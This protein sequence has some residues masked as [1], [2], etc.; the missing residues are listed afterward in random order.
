MFDENCLNNEREGQNVWLNCL[1][2]N[3]NILFQIL[4]YLTKRRFC[5]QIICTTKTL[6]F[7]NL[8]LENEDLGNL[9]RSFVEVHMLVK[10]DDSKFDHFGV[11]GKAVTF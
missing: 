3:G 4:L 9:A 7:R 11:S 10:I 1:N 5:D 2:N 6:K 8:D